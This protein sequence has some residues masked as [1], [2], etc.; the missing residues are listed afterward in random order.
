MEQSNKRRL[1]L[2]AVLCFAMAMLF[3]L[4]KQTAF[5][6]S[7]VSI[8]RIDYSEENIIINNEG[9]SKIYFATEAEADKGVWE[10]IAVT[11]PNGTTE[12]DFSYLSPT[13]ANILVF[14][15]ESD[16]NKKNPV[17]VIINERAKKLSVTINYERADDL[18]VGSDIAELVNIQATI[19]NGN[20]PIKFADLEWKKG[21]GGTWYKCTDAS[22]G[23]TVEKLQRYMIKGTTLYF[24]IEAVDIPSAAGIDQYGRNSGR[25]YSDDIKVIITKRPAAPKVVK[26][27]D[28]SK[29]TAAL[30]YGQ[31][32]RTPSMGN[33]WI[34]ITD[35]KVKAMDLTEIVGSGDGYTSKFPSVVIEYRDYATSKK[36]ASKI[37]TITMPEQRVPNGVIINGDVPNLIDPAKE[38][39]YVSYSSNKYLVITIPSASTSKPFEYAI[40]KKGDTDYSNAKWSAVTKNT[41]VKIAATKAKDDYELIVRLKEIKNKEI[42]STLLKL[43][44]STTDVTYSITYPSVPSIEPILLEYMKGENYSPEP[45]FV[46]KLNDPGKVPSETDIESVKLGTKEIVIKSVDF[47]TDATGSYMRVTLKRESLNTMA[48]CTNKILTITFKNKTVN[49]TSVRITIT[50]PKAAASLDATPSPG[51]A[52]G[53]TAIALNP[54]ASGN[55]YVVEVGAK[56]TGKT[57]SDKV[58]GTVPTYTSG[59]DINVTAGQYVTIYEINATTRNI[60]A[61]K[62]IEISASHIKN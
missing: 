13:K 56:V 40:M 31:E 6:A 16:A 24:R 2:V 4:P 53:T 36:A 44:G 54:P 60:V 47:A 51:S 34:R 38:D 5:A 46:V 58:G 3:A 42:A 32:Y 50:V 27:I 37:S 11:N 35:K 17:R 29:F 52:V 8:A 48:V 15:G 26:G 19:G 62:S 39:V 33:A 59:S 41:P 57:T 18:A 43:Q 61:F 30:K 55:I 25:R 20:S 9:N 14:A 22:K 21:E 1:Q 28:G 7:Q 12:I 23:L 49:K 10:E 45:Y